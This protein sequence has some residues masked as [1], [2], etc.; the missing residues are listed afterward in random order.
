MF[1][2]AHFLDNKINLSYLWKYFEILLVKGYGKLQNTSVNI[3]S[4]RSQFLRQVLD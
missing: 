4:Y 1:S 2:K 3:N